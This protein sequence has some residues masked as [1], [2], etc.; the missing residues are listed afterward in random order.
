MIKYFYLRNEIRTF[1]YTLNNLNPIMKTVYDVTVKDRKNKEVK[2]D[3]YKG[4]VL[5]IVNTATKC[6]FTPQYTELESLYEKYH[7]QEF[8]I[9][10]FPC[11]QFGQQ[12]PGTNEEIHE[13]CKLNYNTEFP[14]FK[15]TDVNGAKQSELFK[16]L[17]EQKTFAGFDPN[18]PITH[19]LEDMLEKSD[20]DYKNNSDI[21]WNF[22]KFLV[23]RHG[24]V[25]KRFEPTESM[26]NVE[27]EIKKLL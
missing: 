19:I 18:H 10:D 22:T 21:K 5:L 24:L 20:P 7:N 3:S 26:E 1:T 14:Q 4:M 27:N 15:K 17:K 6:G 2:L 23:N 12:A 13:F 11:N 25:V 9:L 8:T 16:Y